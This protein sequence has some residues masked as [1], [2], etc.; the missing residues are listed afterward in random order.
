[1]FYINKSGERYPQ[2]I[3]MRLTKD[4]QKE[5]IKVDDDRYY[6]LLKEANENKQELYVE[7]GEIAFS[8]SDNNKIEELIFEKIRLQ[9][10]LKNTDYIAIKCNER[11]L[12]MK[13]EYPK[14]F[15]K[16]Q[17]ARDRINELKTLIN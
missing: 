2:E 7:D 17:E 5:F 4:I 9:S 16:R 3:F 13:E 14:E 15:V 6:E 10:Y 12:N 11:E 8:F 1:M